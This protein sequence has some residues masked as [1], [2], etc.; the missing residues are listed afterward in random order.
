ML[1]FVS[2]SVI[3]PLSTSVNLGFALLSQ[4]GWFTSFCLQSN[5]GCMRTT[6]ELWHCCA[7]HPEGVKEDFDQSELWR[8]SLSPTLG[9]S[10][11]CTCSPGALRIW[12]TIFLQGC[13]SEMQILVIWASDNAE[14]ILQF[15]GR[16]MTWEKWV[17]YFIHLYFLQ[18]SALLR[19]CSIPA[20][21][22]QPIYIYLNIHIWATTLSLSKWVSPVTEFSGNAAL[23]I[24]L[25]CSN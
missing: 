24:N 2:F 12:T 22:Y 11:R 18:Y 4:G 7:N 9:Y 20:N 17:Q 16:S 10:Q 3:P 23:E 5:L 14:I 25:E 19:V 6:W 21:E 8:S 1:P 15:S 13:T